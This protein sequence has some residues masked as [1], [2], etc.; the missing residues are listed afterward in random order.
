[1]GHSW[2]ELLSQLA[3]YLGPLYDPAHFNTSIISL[4]ISSLILLTTYSLASFLI[5]SVIFLSNF[6]VSLLFSS[7]LTPLALAWGELGILRGSLL[8]CLL[9]F[10]LGVCGH[11]CASLYL[12]LQELARN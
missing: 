7:P 3:F 9:M 10:L 4:V 2:F 12:G 11:M 1:M 5:S 6:G 8:L